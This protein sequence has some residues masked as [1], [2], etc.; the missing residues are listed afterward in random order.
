MAPPPSA[1]IANP[2]TAKRRS[3]C[4]RSRSPSCWMR[5]PD[6]S[7]RYSNGLAGGV[8]L[9]VA[10]V[11]GAEPAV[12]GGLVGVGVDVVLFV[13]LDDDDVAGV[14]GL[15]AAV[16]PEGAFALHDAEDL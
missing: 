7:R 3:V 14:D 15:G 8:L 16:D 12:D 5:L 6:M 2:P 4:A 13:G 1:R 11:V 10:G 9:R